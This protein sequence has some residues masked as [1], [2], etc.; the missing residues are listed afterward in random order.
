MNLRASTLCLALLSS[1]LMAGCSQSRLLQ[2]QSHFNALD[3]SS[4]LR[5]DYVEAYEGASATSLFVSA[6]G[7]VCLRRATGAI[8]C[9]VTDTSVI[10]QA[11]ENLGP[12]QPW[13]HSA[14]HGEFAQV[15]VESG[16]EIYLVGTYPPEIEDLLALVDRVFVETF[17]GFYRR[18]FV[19]DLPI[20]IP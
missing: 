6:S 7:R 9:R 13:E 19:Q 4:L 18:R 3:A 14:F 20:Q 15:R 16:T 17:G 2:S 10:V 8:K 5:V 11:V 1:C 12:L